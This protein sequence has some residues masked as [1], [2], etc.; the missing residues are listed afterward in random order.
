MLL[1]Y[2][3]PTLLKLKY[4]TDTDTSRHA[5][6]VSR[7]SHCVP[8]YSHRHR[9]RDVRRACCARRSSVA[10]PTRLSASSTSHS[11]VLTLLKCAKNRTRFGLLVPIPSLARRFVSPTSCDVMR[12]IFTNDVTRMN[13]M[14]IARMSL[15]VQRSMRL[16]MAAVPRSYQSA[17][18]SS[19]LGGASRAAR[20]RS[21]EISAGAASS[22][23]SRSSLA[24]AGFAVIST[25]ATATATPPGARAGAAAGAGA[26]AAAGSRRA[27]SVRSSSWRRSCSVR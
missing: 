24:H 25:S 21:A 8:R 4:D 10:M 15:P 9:R 23:S 11:A 22:A 16:E 6:D 13:D 1:R 26:A 7:Y 19:L 14:L 17:P 3:A 2:T 5:H 18:C 27:I 12:T 20:S